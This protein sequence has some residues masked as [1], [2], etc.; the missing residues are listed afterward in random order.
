MDELQIQAQINMNVLNDSIFRNGGDIKDHVINRVDP[1][2]IASGLLNDMAAITMYGNC[3][4]IGPIKIGGLSME[5][6]EEDFLLNFNFISDAALDDI[7]ESERPKF[8]KLE[9]IKSPEIIRQCYYATYV[10]FKHAIIMSFSCLDDN[11]SSGII[12]NDTFSITSKRMYDIVHGYQ[13]YAFH[14]ESGEHLKFLAVK[15][16]RS[17]FNEKPEMISLCTMTDI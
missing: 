14:I 2:L 1:E 5:Y 12:F 15:P 4:P 9:S 8:A 10:W 6:Y 13:G 16:F 7:Y 3:I 11:C 17:K